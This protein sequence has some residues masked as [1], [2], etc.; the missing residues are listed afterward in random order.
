MRDVLI[1]LLMMMV[2]VVMT[3]SLANINMFELKCTY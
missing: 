3:T 1:R 2:V